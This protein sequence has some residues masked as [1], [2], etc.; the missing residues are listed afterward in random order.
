M[1]AILLLSVYNGRAGSPPLHSYLEAAVRLLGRLDVQR[2]AMGPEFIHFRTSF[3]PSPTATRPESG[4][5]GKP[6]LGTHGVGVR[7]ISPSLVILTGVSILA[8]TSLRRPTTSGQGNTA[9]PGDSTV[10]AP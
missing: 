3:R 7:S 1:L 2:S 8:Q 5:L 6:F 10:S 4:V 9:K